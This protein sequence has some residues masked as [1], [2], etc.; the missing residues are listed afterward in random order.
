MVYS[1]Q[2][3]GPIYHPGSKY[4]VETMTTGPEPGPWSLDSSLAWEGCSCQPSLC[5][6]ISVSFIFSWE[7]RLFTLDNEN[8]N[9]KCQKYHFNNI[10]SKNGIFTSHLL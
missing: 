7:R 1:M 9:Y 6:H 10:N 5:G 8:A 4:F 3:M 2:G